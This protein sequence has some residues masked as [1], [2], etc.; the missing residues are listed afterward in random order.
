MRYI[1]VILILVSIMLSS[2]IYAGWERTYG[3]NLND[4][5]NALIQ[6]TDGN[7]IIAG[8]TESFG[9]GTSGS[10]VVYVL[11]INGSGD[12]LWTKTY[13][14][15]YD[16]AHCAIESDDGSIYIAGDTYSYSSG[17]A[18][19][20]LIKLNSDGDSLWTKAYGGPRADHCYDMILTQD[21]CIILTGD[22]DTSPSSGKTWLAKVNME[23]EM[24]WSK[25][26]G[27]SDVFQ[28]GKWVIQL[29]DSSFILLSYTCVSGDYSDILLMKT[30][31]A[32]DTLISKEY[33]GIYSD[34]GSEIVAL[35]EGFVLVGTS[36]QSTGLD[37][38][39][40]WVMK[41]DE[42]CD[43]LLTKKFRIEGQSTR[44]NSISPTSDGGYIV[45]GTYGSFMYANAKI[46][47]SKLDTDLNILW[48]E[49]F[50]S[51]GYNDGKV[52]IETSDCGFML[53]A[54]TN[55]LGEGGYDIYVIRTDSLGSSTIEENQ[56]LPRTPEIS[57]HPNPFNSSVRI[58]VEGEWDS[59]VQ[60]EIYDVAGRKIVES[61]PAPLIKGGARRAGGSYY[62]QPD[63]TL[64]SGVYLV[65]ARYDS[66][67][68]SGVETTAT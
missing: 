68:L 10:H 30:N 47:L 7:Y 65:R 46:F 44:A 48:T 66:R 27:A 18:D 60:I 2:Q 62:W 26:Y 64:P 33:G 21:S 41:F 4:R 35:E 59:P 43:T 39:D 11:K 28:S 23:G 6:T 32:G 19:I 63:E 13:G 61:P 45:T 22:V 3:G 51:F 67:S 16:E 20:W 5:V 36:S 40:G 12:T 38:A 56:S 50:G 15:D 34:W 31:E 49:S 42:F 24:L 9:F 37:N 25:E 29:H 14:L 55:S 53:C 8:R 1:K 58:E 52:V 54:N 57:A 17:S